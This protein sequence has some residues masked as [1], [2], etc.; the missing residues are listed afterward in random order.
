MAGA[1]GRLQRKAVVTV[2]VSRSGLVQRAAFAQSSGNKQ[3]DAAAI[4]AT[5]ATAFAPA[6]RQCVAI[7]STFHYALG[8]GA[9]G[10]LQTAVVPSSSIQLTS[11]QT[12]R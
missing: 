3:F 9:S 12:R 10:A 7:D 6:A 4:A 8:Y 1:A 2:V 5:E 11:T